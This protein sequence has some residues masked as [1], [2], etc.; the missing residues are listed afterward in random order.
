[1]PEKLRIILIIGPESGMD[2]QQQQICLASGSPRRR[3]LLDQIGVRYMVKVAQIDESVR[4]NE[5]ADDFVV[6]LALEKARCIRMSGVELPV[7]SAD[8]AVV[9]DD[10]ILGK[11]SDRD[12]A[13]NMLRLLSGNEHTV[14]T[15]VSLVAE[16]ESFRLSTS[17][18][19]FREMSANE[20]ESYC[21]SGEPMDKAGAYAI[22]GKAAVFIENLQG[23]YSGVM[24]LP[25]FE[26]ADL[27]REFDINIF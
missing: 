11:P 18:V 19:R 7:L 1:M 12:A 6:R 25:L 5:H 9:I 24:G 3:E 22:Q 26:T 16:R 23:S 2:E 17:R 14:H 4:A 21:D 13:I 8:T 27:L 10:R 15:A 20:I